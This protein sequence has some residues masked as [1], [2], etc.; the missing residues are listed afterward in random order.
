MIIIKPFQLSGTLS[1]E[2]HGLENSISCIIRLYLEDYNG[3]C[4]LCPFMNSFIQK[5]HP[6]SRYVNYFYSFVFL[7][8]FTFFFSL[9]R[10]YKNQFTFIKL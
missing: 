4:F 2:T 3:V 8:N 9:N 1:I 10:S 7:K 5:V 6:S